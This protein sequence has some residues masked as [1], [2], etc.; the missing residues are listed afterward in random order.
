MF[1]IGTPDTIHSNS[2]IFEAEFNKQD[3]KQV[4]YQL[5]LKLSLLCSSATPEIPLSNV[6]R[7]VC[8]KLP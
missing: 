5:L 6:P 8:P 2:K 1:V 4:K 7:E 3:I